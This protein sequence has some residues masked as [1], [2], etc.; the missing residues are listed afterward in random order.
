MPGAWEV[1]HGYRANGFRRL[2]MSDFRNMVLCIEF[3]DGFGL[4]C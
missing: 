1:G 2:G 3:N 4:K